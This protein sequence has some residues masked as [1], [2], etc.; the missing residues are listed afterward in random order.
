[1]H[2]LK[3]SPLIA[4]YNDP[5]PILAKYG[6]HHY[7]QNVHCHFYSITHEL[8]LHQALHNPCQ[9]EHCLPF[10]FSLAPSCGIISSSTFLR[11][12]VIFA[13][14]YFITTPP[15][16]DNL[17]KYPP[18]DNST[19]LQ[20]TQTSSIRSVLYCFMSLWCV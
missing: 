10:Q 6:H 1:M 16:Y 11:V 18:P 17:E 5:L 19:P 20:L 7:Q 15:L 9:M 4:F 12:A 13:A 14:G 3:F 2:F 8:T